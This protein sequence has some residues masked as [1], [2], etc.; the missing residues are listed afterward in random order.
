MDPEVERLRE[1]AGPPAEPED[2]LTG[3]GGSQDF[4]RHF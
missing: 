3:G 2:D 4:G 1:T